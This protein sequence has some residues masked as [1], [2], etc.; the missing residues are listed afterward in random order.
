MTSAIPAPTRVVG[1]L[2]DLDGL[3]P[4]AETTA[5]SDPQAAYQRLRD[6]WGMVAP[7]QLERFCRISLV[8]YVGWLAARRSLRR[9]VKLARP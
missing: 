8:G 7:I 1:R 4:L 2:S 3:T 9:R 5:T 6:Q